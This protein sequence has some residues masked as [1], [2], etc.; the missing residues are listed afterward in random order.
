MNTLSFAEQAAYRARLRGSLLGGA[1]GSALGRPVE[2]MSLAMI[3][4]RYGENGVT[5]PEADHEG[6][7]G[8]ISADTQL[9]LFTA[10]GW[11]AGYSRIMEKGISG[12][13]VTIVQQ[14]YLSWLGTQEHP[15]PPADAPSLFAGRLRGQQWLYARRGAGEG[16]LAG[17]KQGHVPDPRSEITGEPGPVNPHSKGCGALARSAPFGFTGTYPK[18]YFELAARCAQITH[19]HP[20]GYLAAGAFAVIVNQ[21]VRGESLYRAVQLALELLAGY[22]RHEETTAALRRALAL[23]AAGPATP[24]AVETLGHGT[25]AEETLAIA[26]Y[27]ALAETTP[28]RRH[29]RI[30]RALLLAVNHSGD[31]DSTGAVCGNLLGAQLG[32]GMLPAAWLDRLEGRAEIAVLADAFASAVHPGEVLPRYW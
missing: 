2:Q 20:T 15:A 31:S 13:E 30:E 16:T 22:P 3:R 1:L 11:R 12:A 8:R 19:G 25:V 14:S 18:T 24:E 9:T 10:D 21:L 17:L 6:V 29:T 26:V 23:A 27:A 7:T 32:D 5:G 4:A 28:S